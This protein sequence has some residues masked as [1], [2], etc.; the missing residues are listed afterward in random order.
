MGVGQ[1]AA[2]GV[3]REGAARRGFAIL[4]EGHTRT[5]FAEAKRFQHD[6]WAGGKGVVQHDV[7]EIAVCDTGHFERLIAGIPGCHAHG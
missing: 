1:T 5:R 2:I 7:I 6:W 4:E 3:D